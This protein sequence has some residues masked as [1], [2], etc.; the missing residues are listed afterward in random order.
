MIWDNLGLRSW[1]VAVRQLAV[2]GVFWLLVLFYAP[3]V[4]A[5]QAPVN[6]DNLKKVWSFATAC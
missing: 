3:I 4:A 1:E 6:M 5:I 2:W